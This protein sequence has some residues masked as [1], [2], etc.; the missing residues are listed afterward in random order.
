MEICSTIEMGIFFSW[1]VSEA[2]LFGES[3]QKAKT[4]VLAGTMGV[5]EHLQCTEDVVWAAAVAISRKQ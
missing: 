4:S 2:A 5:L 3:T 1:S